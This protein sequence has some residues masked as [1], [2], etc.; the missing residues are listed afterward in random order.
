MDQYSM[1]ASLFA[2]AATDTVSG[3]MFVVYM[4]EWT[5]LNDDNQSRFVCFFLPRTLIKR[6][7]CSFP[8][9]KS[10][11]IDKLVYITY[12]GK[13]PVESLELSR[14]NDRIGLIWKYQGRRPRSLPC[15]NWNTKTLGFKWNQRDRIRR[16]DVSWKWE[17]EGTGF[18]LK[19]T[20][21]DKAGYPSE[22]CFVLSRF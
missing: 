6:R 10:T 20:G 15:W 21:R 17:R 8:R 7:I 5:I 3:G 19:A 13:I 16:D 2:T 11:K 4:F 9:S 14:V 12:Y 18:V 1:S 22:S